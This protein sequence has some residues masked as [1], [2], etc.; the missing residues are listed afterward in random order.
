M[1]LNPVIMNSIESPEYVAGQTVQESLERQAAALSIPLQDQT[2]Y[3]REEFFPDYSAEIE[4]IEEEGI[5]PGIIKS[6][7]QKHAPKAED[8]LRKYNRYRGTITGVPIYQRELP[9][10]Q[11]VKVNNKLNNDFFSEIVDTKV[12]YGFGNPVKIVLDTSASQHAAITA[13]I[14]D[15]QVRNNLDDMNGQTCKMAAIC[16]YDA[17]LLYNDTEANR[18]IMRV[19]PWEVIILSRGEI[20]MPQY[21]VRYYQRYDKI[22]HIE[23]YDGI[24]KTVFRG[25]S[26]SDLTVFEE[27]SPHFYNGVPLV[28][29]PNNTEMLGDSDKQLNLIDAYNRAASDLTSEVEQFRLAYMIAKNCD[30]DESVVAMLRKTGIL[31]IDDNPDN[32]AEISYLEKNVNTAAVQTVLDILEDNIIRFSGH[33]NMTDEAFAGD[34]SGVAIRYK[35]IKLENKTKYFELKHKAALW[36]VFKLLADA[37]GQ[38]GAEAFNYTYLTFKYTRNIPVNLLDEANTAAALGGLISRRTQMGMLSVVDDVDDEEAQIEKEKE[39]ER[40][41]QPQVIEPELLDEEDEEIEPAQKE[42]EDGES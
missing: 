27:A 21:A 40:M 34:L 25:T 30:F 20:T 33:V 26:W 23:F 16:G 39:A 37:W 9:T 29:V 10:G 28:G 31:N 4:A 17:W 35:L 11:E 19:N 1:T 6:L 2:E 7:L 41:K 32:P 3:I 5:T 18:R 22:W 14:Q 36:H 12:G 13:Q 15:F 24:N 8:M 42:Q 38:T